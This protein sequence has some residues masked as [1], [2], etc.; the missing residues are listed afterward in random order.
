MSLRD[1]DVVVF[2]GG[3]GTRLASAWDGPKCLAPVGG[4]PFVFYVLDQLVAAGASRVILALAHRA[5]EV[6]RAMRETYSAPVPIE[7]VFS[8]DDG[9]H[10]EAGALREALATQITRDK[11]LTL[12]GDTYVVA[13]LATPA[14]VFACSRRASMCLDDPEGI[15]SGAVFYRLDSPMVGVGPRGHELGYGFIDIGTPRGYRGAP[16]Y[17]RSLGFE[18]AAP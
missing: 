5:D 11:L 9:E 10:G 4:R 17:L 1:F 3:K 13:S 14:N 7:I 15:C 18:V 8:Q 2:A 12:N 16:C 6:R